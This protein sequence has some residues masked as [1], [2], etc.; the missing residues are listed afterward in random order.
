M[1]RLP[2]I[3]ALRLAFCSLVLTLCTRIGWD[4]GCDVE[5]QILHS[6]SG[7]G[8]AIVRRW[9]S[10]D[11][12]RLESWYVPDGREEQKLLRLR[13]EC[14][15]GELPHSFGIKRHQSQPNEESGHVWGD[16]L[17]ALQT[18]G[19]LAIGV[20]C[21]GAHPYVD[22]NVMQ[23]NNSDGSSDWMPP[24]DGASADEVIEHLIFMGTK[25]LYTDWE[26]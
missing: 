2:A 24:K 5:G 14:A 25:Y 11:G 26:I 13:D 18:A 21:A 8:P 3:S 9:T 23:F 22:S 4:Q 6:Q 17:I 15:V 10:P 1:A 7:H 12:C 19:G 16:G 20:G